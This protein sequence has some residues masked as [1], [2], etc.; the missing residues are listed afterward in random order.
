MLVG[1]RAASGEVCGRLPFPPPVSSPFFCPSLPISVFALHPSLPGLPLRD[2][3]CP[4]R[5]PG[6][7]VWEKGKGERK[8]WMEEVGA[9]GS[10]REER[11]MMEGGRSRE[12]AE[13]ERKCL[14]YYS[15]LHVLLPDYYSCLHLLLHHYYLSLPSHY[16]LLLL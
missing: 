15:L 10:G 14:Y 16:Y 13:G 8:G 12:E 2:P 9:G 4:S 5:T 6:P 11:I 1:G 3:L 7:F